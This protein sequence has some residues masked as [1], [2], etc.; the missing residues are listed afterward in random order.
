MRL[1]LL[2]FL[3][4]T[5]SVTNSHAQI[6]WIK[7]T[8]LKLI[9]G[10]PKASD[11]VSEAARKASKKNE[12]VITENLDELACTIN[13]IDENLFEEV[14]EVAELLANKHSIFRTKYTRI[15]DGIAD[16]IYPL[17]RKGDDGAVEVYW[18]PYLQG[19]LHWY[20]EVGL[21]VDL[22]ET[23]GRSLIP[24]LARIG[25][26]SVHRDEMGQLITTYS[27]EVLEIVSEEGESIYLVL[28]RHVDREL[29]ALER[30]GF[31]VFRNEEA[32]IKFADEVKVELGGRGL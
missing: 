11:E 16:P 9:Y 22:S 17:I 3:I 12:E 7:K 32:A 19:A 14:D 13:K 20:K 18:E 31:A 23:T 26:V 8:C 27:R 21:K 28:K 25:K 6:N 29:F 30:Q 4:A 15:G 10:A 5:S 2:L 1:L 24:Y